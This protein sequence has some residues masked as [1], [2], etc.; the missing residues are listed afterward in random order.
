MNSRNHH[1]YS[2]VGQILHEDIAGLSQVCRQVLLLWMI[3]CVRCK[4]RLASRDRCF[5][6]RMF[7]AFP[8]PASFRRRHAGLFHSNGNGKQPG[9]GRHM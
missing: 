2:T 5:V 7:A 6:L 1:M 9:H 8:R 4:A 3:G